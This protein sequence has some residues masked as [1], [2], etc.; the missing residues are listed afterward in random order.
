MGKFSDL[1]NEKWEIY[2]EVTRKIMCEISGLK[3]SNKT[4]RDSKYYEN[5]LYKGIYEEE[6]NDLLFGKV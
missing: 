5:S 6:K 3:P 2:A 4:F 1:G